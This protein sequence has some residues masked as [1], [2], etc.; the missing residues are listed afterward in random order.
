MLL[1][2]RFSMSSEEVPG[3]VVGGPATVPDGRV[4]SIDSCT[5]TVLSYGTILNHAGPRPGSDMSLTISIGS[6]A[7]MVGGCC[8]YQNA[9]PVM[10]P[11]WLHCKPTLYPGP[12]F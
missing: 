4:V 7:G 9:L 1:R 2:L 10:M 8:P 6:G 3:V 5:T 11:D 12:V